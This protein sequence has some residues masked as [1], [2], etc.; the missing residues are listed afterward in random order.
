MGKRTDDGF[1]F[2]Q[3]GRLFGGR[4]GYN[5]IRMVIHSDNR[6]EIAQA[7]CPDGPD[8]CQEGYWVTA[9]RLPSGT[10]ASDD[11]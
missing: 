5:E 4:P 8:S 9:T 10:A 2:T 6:Y 11:S 3:G 1:V 7:H